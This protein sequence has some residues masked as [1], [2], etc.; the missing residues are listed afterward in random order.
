MI[1][2]HPRQQP[3]GNQDR[4]PQESDQ[5]RRLGQAGFQQN[6]RAG[7][8]QPRR[9]RSQPIL[10]LLRR[11]DGSPLTQPFGR[12]PPSRR[13]RIEGNNARH[14]E[15]HNPRQP[16]RWGRRRR[17][18]CIGARRRGPQAMVNRR[19]D[20]RNGSRPQDR[21][22]NR[23]DRQHPQHAH[24]RQRV[25]RP[26]GSPPAQV[27]SRAHQ[28]RDQRA[29]PQ[30]VNQR[31]PERLRHRR[32][33]Q[34]DQ[35]V[36]RP[37]FAYSSSSPRISAS[38]FADALRAESAPKIRLFAEPPKARWSRSPANCRCVHSRGRSAS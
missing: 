35:R 3:R 38:S 9:Q 11:R 22:R 13:A 26:R 25:A 24:A 17:G 28:R 31:P 5:H 1:R 16:V 18:K 27:E 37:P 21:Q 15:R 14:P 7:E 19:R 23:E 2:S 34:K 6:H 12:Q 32:A 8:A 4:R 36:H 29:F 20:A 10:P 30:K 33:D